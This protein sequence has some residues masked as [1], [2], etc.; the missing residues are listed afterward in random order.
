MAG[1]KQSG[2][3][4]SPNNFEDHKKATQDFAKRPLKL[5]MEVPEYQKYYQYLKD[6]KTQ[7]NQEYYNRYALKYLNL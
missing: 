3:I 4:G 7:F 5:N 2:N 1:H 6:N